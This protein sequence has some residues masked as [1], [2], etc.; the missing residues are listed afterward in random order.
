MIHK[1][2]GQPWENYLTEKVFSPLGMNF[3]RATNTNT[4]LPNLAA[5][6]RDNDRLL[7]APDWQAL[8]PSG[9]FFS[10]VQDLARWD[11]ALDSNRIL[12]ESSRRL[13]WTRVSLNDGSSGPYGLGWYVDELDGHRRVHHGGGIP[14]FSADFSRFPDAG[15]TVIV[16]VNL[17]DNNIETI[18][19]GVAM[20]YLRE[21][22]PAR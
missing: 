9:A 5:G 4:R 15:V 11:A 20:I 6:Y 3:T 19:D 1:V 2:S 21:S 13:M 7:D 17:D 18:A 14:G 12:S 16:L 22:S 8:R 10:T